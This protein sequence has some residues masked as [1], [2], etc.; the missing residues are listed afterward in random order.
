MATKAK[1]NTK[2]EPKK[3]KET[4]TV[5]AKP[6]PKTAPKKS[7]TEIVHTPPIAEA[8]VPAPVVRYFDMGESVGRLNADGS[9]TKLTLIG[10]V[11]STTNVENADVSKLTEITK[12]TAYERVF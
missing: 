6:E 4:K 3:A 7:V 12:Q 8:P 9:F 11:Q 1:P 10:G 5:K 2:V